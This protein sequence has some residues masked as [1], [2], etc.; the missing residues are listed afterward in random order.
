MNDYTTVGENC[1]T[2][3]PFLL[4]SLLSSKFNTLRQSSAP[5]GVQALHSNPLFS[6]DA[7]LL[8]SLSTSTTGNMHGSSSFE[9]DT[10]SDI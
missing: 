8:P 4:S 9:R 3:L 7:S 10:I 6:G 2:Y 1:L 5:R